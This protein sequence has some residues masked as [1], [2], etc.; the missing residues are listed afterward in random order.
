MDYAGRRF[1]SDKFYAGTDLL[2]YPNVNYGDMRKSW[3]VI[4]S[5][6]P[7]R[8]NRIESHF[9]LFQALSLR[10]LELK[11]KI[12]KQLVAVID[13]VLQRTTVSRIDV[14]KAL[15]IAFIDHVMEVK[16]DWLFE[17]KHETVTTVDE[18]VWPSIAKKLKLTRS[19][20]IMVG[21]GV[22]VTFEIHSRV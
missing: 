12:E 1:V 3:W 20:T 16:V 15:R 14:T 7:L 22:D 10:I 6:Q 18:S 19:Q 5:I 21:N 17:D 13:E 11:D 2:F 4:V 9:I 8:L